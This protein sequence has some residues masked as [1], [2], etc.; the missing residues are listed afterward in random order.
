MNEAMLD[1]VTGARLRLEAFMLIRGMA[2]VVGRRRGAG[3]RPLSRPRRFTDGWR[4]GECSSRD[5]G[6]TA[7]AI[8]VQEDV[9]RVR[10]PS[11]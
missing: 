3:Q 8:D 5:A 10:P 4:L 11:E 9:R 2:P 1:P 6:L 7:A